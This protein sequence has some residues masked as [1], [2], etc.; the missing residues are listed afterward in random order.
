MAIEK[1]SNLLEDKNITKDLKEAYKFMLL[2]RGYSAEDIK[3]IDDYVFLV[4]KK[5]DEDTI[6]GGITQQNEFEPLRKRRKKSLPKNLVC[7]TSTSDYY[8]KQDHTLYSLND[9]EPVTKGRL[10]WSIIRYYQEQYNPTFDEVNQLFNFKL[11]LLRK[12]VIDVSSLDV[13]RADRQ[14][15]F[16]YHESDLLESKDGI[17]YAV[18]NQ[19]S[20]R[21]M[22]EIVKFAQSIGSKIEIVKPFKK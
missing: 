5:G 20:F 3:I 19:W 21:Y 12:T 14:K 1:I 10:V 15:R 16:Y 22:D 18:S 11:H 2:S 6:N 7:L 4:K 13:L 9:N 8:N 17:Q